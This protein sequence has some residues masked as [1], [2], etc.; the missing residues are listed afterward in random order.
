MTLT[1][2]ASAI[3]QALRT[4][5]KLTLRRGGQRGCGSP[6]EDFIA[7]KNRVVGVK[8]ANRRREPELHKP[9]LLAP[10]IASQTISYGWQAQIRSERLR[11]TLEFVF[12]SLI[13]RTTPQ[14]KN[15]CPCD[16]TALIREGY[17]TRGFEKENRNFDTNYVW[18]Q[19]QK[20]SKR[21]VHNSCDRNRRV[22]NSP[23]HS[24]L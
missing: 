14:Q 10:I 23:H 15:S 22:R 13:T 20:R 7:R 16:R 4:R 17:S 11:P 1:E 3:D 9:P 21:E 5:R 18:R 2:D 12:S 19:H 8:E 6:W 24:L